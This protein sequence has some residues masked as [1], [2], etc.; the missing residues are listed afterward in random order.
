M[1]ELAESTIDFVGTPSASCG[2]AK[3]FVAFGGSAKT[4]E[5]FCGFAESAGPCG[6]AKSP[7]PFGFAITAA[8]MP[9][10]VRRGSA[11]P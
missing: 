3:P 4:A 7:R 9:P 11:P 8:A 5:L 10:D 1:M 2:A 6:F